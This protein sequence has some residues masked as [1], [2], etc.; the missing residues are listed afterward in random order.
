MQLGVRRY[1]VYLT[2]GVARILRDPRVQQL[3]SSRLLVLVLWEDTATHVKQVPPG[4]DLYQHQV[5]A[6]TLS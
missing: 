4:L 3:V 5:C 2:H 1:L 6:D